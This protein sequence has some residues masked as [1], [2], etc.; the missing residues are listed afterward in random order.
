VCSATETE[1][2]GYDSEPYKSIDK[3]VI[4][5]IR[6]EANKYISDPKEDMYNMKA[7]K[8]YRILVELIVTPQENSNMR[9]KDLDVHPSYR[10]DNF[11]WVDNMIM[12]MDQNTKI[13]Y[14]NCR[15]AES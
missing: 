7:G 15:E 14:L 9:D 13:K 6:Q 5:K 4:E 12:P 11:D 1:F 8:T 10:I 2:R 3:E